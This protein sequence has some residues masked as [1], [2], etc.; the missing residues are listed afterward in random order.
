M[1]YKCIECGEDCAIENLTDGVCR[2]CIN[3]LGDDLELCYRVGVGD[4]RE[5]AING[6]LFSMFEIEDIEDILLTHLQMDKRLGYN[7]N[8][9]EYIKEDVDWFI[10]QTRGEN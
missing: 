5:I 7:V 3:K 1:R 4:K 6:F 8:G 9:A 2:S 10:R